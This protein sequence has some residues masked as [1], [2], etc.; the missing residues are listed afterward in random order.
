MTENFP[1]RI[2]E[3]TREDEQSLLRMI[4]ELRQR[5]APQ[6]TAWTD[7]DDEAGKLM[8]VQWFQTLRAFRV[9]HVAEAIDVHLGGPRGPY[10]P[11]LQELDE[12]TTHVSR[13]RAAGL[14][15]EAIAASSSH[16][17]GDGWIR[18]DDD[19]QMPCGRC[20]PYLRAVYNDRDKWHQYLNG[21]PLTSLGVGVE[22]VGGK[23]IAESM[24][25]PCKID[26]THE[27]EPRYSKEQYEETFGRLRKAKR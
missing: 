14:R 22:K 26:D 15:H 25:S 2:T 19:R 6:R 5:Y 27:Q 8:T 23:L 24:P 1:A 18:T 9:E 10:F 4:V 16:C 17:S 3:T 13:S 11:T 12:T 7:L 21:T 20:N